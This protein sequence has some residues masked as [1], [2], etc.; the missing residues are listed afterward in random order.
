MVNGN[1]NGKGK[2]FA[3]SPSWYQSPLS[4]ENPMISVCQTHH[5][6]PYTHDWSF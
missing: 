4:S 2:P 5:E 3:L 6:I 1:G